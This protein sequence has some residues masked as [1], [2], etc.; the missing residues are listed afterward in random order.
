MNTTTTPEH[1]AGLAALL[2]MQRAAPAHRARN[3]CLIVA[4][5]GHNMGCLTYAVIPNISRRD[6]AGRRNPGAPVDVWLPNGS[7]PRK[8]Y[9]AVLIAEWSDM[10]R[11]WA[12]GWTTEQILAQAER[13]IPR[14]A[15]ATDVVA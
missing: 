13:M 14:Y 11:A 9:Q 6:L 10:T 2:E 15:R 3:L 12:N 1:F 4:A 5:D 7:D 8:S